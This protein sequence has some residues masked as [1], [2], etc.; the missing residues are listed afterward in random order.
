MT[1]HPNLIFSVNV[2]QGDV[3]SHPRVTQGGSETP[4]CFSRH[5]CESALSREVNLTNICHVTLKMLKRHPIFGCASIESSATMSASFVNI[6]G[7]SSISQVAS[8]F[9]Q[10]CPCVECTQYPKSRQYK[11]M[12]IILATMLVYGSFERSFEQRQAESSTAI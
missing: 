3:M 9:F 7:M 1:L 11:S 8:L 4:L 10:Q 2:S 5:R 6:S 12:G